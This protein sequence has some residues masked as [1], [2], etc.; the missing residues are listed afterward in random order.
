MQVGS[1]CFRI[2]FTLM[3][4]RHDSDSGDSHELAT[5]E[6]E[7][8]HRQRRSL[9][10]S[11]EEVERLQLLSNTYV[12][13]SDHTL[14]LEA[15][16]YQNRTLVDTNVLAFAQGPGGEAFVEDTSD[17][18]W[19]EGPGWPFFGRTYI[20]S[21]VLSFAPAG[22]GEVF[23][24]GYDSKL[25][26]ESPFLHTKTFIDADVYAFSSAGLG[27]VY[28]EGYDSNLWLEGANWRT[29]VHSNVLSF[30][31]DENGDAYVEGTDGNLWLEGTG[32]QL[33]GRTFIDGNDV[34]AFAPDGE[35]SLSRG[36]TR[37]SGKSPPAGSGPAGP[38][39]SPTSCPSHRP[40]TGTSS[41]RGPTAT[42]GWSTPSGSSPKAGASSS[43]TSWP[44]CQPPPTPT[45][46]ASPTWARSSDRT[47][48]RRPAPTGP[49]TRPRP[50][51]PI[52]NRIPVGR[53][54][55]VGRPDRHRSVHRLE[56]WID[57]G[58]DRWQCQQYRGADRDLRELC[59]RPARLFRVVG[60]VV[61][62]R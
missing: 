3:P 37:S 58:G 5:L 16:N 51:S 54:R 18:L 8:R 9:R 26:L 41:S 13:G 6:H 23:V 25:W 2:R 43:P 49:A 42:S 40:T 52:R 48:T 34:L 55:L 50:V 22:N 20:E 60:D 10:P 46:W 19:L 35:G 30:A 31:A 1:L 4:A 47:R 12:L 7:T 36:P 45:V 62:R 44:W 24:E 11:L 57:L 27:E 17:R 53:L 61:E 32:W 33:T 15:P 56:L 38:T 21:N 29:F 28:V 14:W 39:S 59:Q